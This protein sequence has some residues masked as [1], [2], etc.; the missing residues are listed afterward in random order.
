[1]WGST[2]QLTQN[3]KVSRKSAVESPHSEPRGPKA[4][5]SPVGGTGERVEVTGRLPLPGGVQCRGWADSLEDRNVIPAWPFS[6]GD[7]RPRGGA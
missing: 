3:P 5:S 1:M 2:Y 7:G 6:L 4:G